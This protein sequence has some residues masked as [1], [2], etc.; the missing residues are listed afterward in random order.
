MG[1][2]RVWLFLSLS[3]LIFPLSKGK[4]SHDLALPYPTWCTPIGSCISSYHFTL[5]STF[6]TTYDFLT[7]HAMFTHFS[8]HLFIFLPHKLHPF[9]HYY[10]CH[11]FIHFRTSTFFHLHPNTFTLFWLHICILPTGTWS[12]FLHSRTFPL[13]TS[14]HTIVFITFS[15]KLTF[16]M[17]CIHSLIFHII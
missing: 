2:R 7:S 6:F 5:S 16:F 10:L 4:L 1:Y 3:T 12:I 17:A 11:I 13:L 14:T 8:Y 15:H 9:A